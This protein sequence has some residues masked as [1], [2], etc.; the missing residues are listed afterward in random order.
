[1][2][3]EK[4][5]LELHKLACELPM[6]KLKSKLISTF[7]VVAIYTTFITKGVSK[8]F[9]YSEVLPT[10]YSSNKCTL[11]VCPKKIANTIIIQLHLFII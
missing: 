9:F 7:S 8:S 3:A 1:M 4:I 5:S 2:N 11:N 6:V 10:D